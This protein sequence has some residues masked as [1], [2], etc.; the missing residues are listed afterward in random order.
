MK[1]Y[2]IKWVTDGCTI[3]L[4]AEVEIPIHII[5]ND[6]D[7][8]DYLS[9]EYGFLVESFEIDDI[10]PKFAVTSE[11]VSMIENNILNG[12]GNETFTGWCE[13]G[14]VF[15]NTFPNRTK[16]FYDECVKLMEQV[17]PLVD[18]LTYN[19]LADL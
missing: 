19:H 1:A 17:A 11:I 2:N 12:Y 8:A 4:P 3:E 7:V 14:V 13:D 18:N 10:T 15:E 6:G 16:E 9:D 5:E